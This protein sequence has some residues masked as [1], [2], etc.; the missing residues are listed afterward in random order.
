MARKL[1][2]A[3]VPSP[4]QPKCQGPGVVSDDEHAAVWRK[5]GAG[6]EEEPAGA[7]ARSS[8]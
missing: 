5:P 7:S 3:P 8:E 1:V 4:K 6:A 2:S